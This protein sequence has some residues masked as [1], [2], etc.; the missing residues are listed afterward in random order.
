MYDAN[1]EEERIITTPR[2]MGYFA[3]RT[4]SIHPPIYLSIHPSTHRTIEILDKKML[5]EGRVDHQME[6]RLQL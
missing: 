1:V 2:F 5:L 4:A 3:D 6:I